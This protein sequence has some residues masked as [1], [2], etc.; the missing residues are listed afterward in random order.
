M[1]KVKTTTPILSPSSNIAPMHT[2]RLTFRPLVKDDLAEVHALRTQE[3]VMIFTMVG[4]I[5]RDMDESQTKLNTYLPPNDIKTYN[6]GIF[7]SSTGEFLGTGGCHKSTGSAAGWPEVGY[8]LKKEYWGK[9]YATEFLRG[10]VDAWWILPRTETEL[11]VDP[12]TVVG[13]EGEGQAAEQLYACIDAANIG[14]LRVMEKLGF[15]KFK[16]WKEPDSRVGYEGQDVLL[17]GYVL[18]RPKP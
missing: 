8:M 12:L 3:E 4:R 13:S 5:D 6:K 10:F 9:G 1:V 16:E 14:S 18:Q 11:E 15:R 2:E 17:F 7:L